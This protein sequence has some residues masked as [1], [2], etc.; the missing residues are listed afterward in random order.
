M[1]FTSQSKQQGGAVDI[2]SAV[3]AQDCVH[4]TT[5][6]KGLKLSENLFGDFSRGFKIW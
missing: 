1:G 4:V 3:S 2:T 5:S 6:I